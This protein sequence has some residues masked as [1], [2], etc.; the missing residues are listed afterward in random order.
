MPMVLFA[1]V[2]GWQQ[3]HPGQ[4]CDGRDSGT[5]LTI[6]CDGWLLTALHWGRARA[7]AMVWGIVRHTVPLQTRNVT[8]HAQLNHIMLLLQVSATNE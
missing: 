2:A 7:Q 6:S 1:Q 3:K 5:C 4:P 8:C